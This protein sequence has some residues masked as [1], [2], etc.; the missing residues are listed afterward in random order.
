MS[1]R[2]YS[3]IVLGFFVLMAGNHFDT[4]IQIRKELHQNR[5]VY[6]GF[7]LNPVT[8]ILEVSEIVN[9]SLLDFALVE[10]RM[11]NVARKNFD[12]YAMLI[13]FRVIY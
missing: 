2:W 10:R 6:K 8:N 7:K 1:K 11:N 12:V 13:P 5:I 4:T 3:L 9:A